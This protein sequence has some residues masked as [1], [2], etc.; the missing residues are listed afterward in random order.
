M[1]LTKEFKF[2][3]AHNL[4]NYHGKCEKLHG[5][6]YRLAVTLQGTPDEEDMVTDFTE[7]KHAVQ[8][9]VLSKFDHAYINDILEQP[10]A[11]NIALRIFKTLDK[12]LEKPN[13]RLFEIKIWETETSSVACR[14]EDLK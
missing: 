5:H 3:A 12:P 6:T 11:E 10:T 14:R 2:N 7:I 13:C 4:V 9:L 8:E 1:F